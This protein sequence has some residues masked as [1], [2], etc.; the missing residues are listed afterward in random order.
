MGSFMRGY[1]LK[2]DIAKS[3]NPI[4][5]IEDLEPSGNLIELDKKIDSLSDLITDIYIHI[6]D[7]EVCDDPRFFR[8]D[9]LVA[10]GRI[11][12]I[13][14]SWA[15]KITEILNDKNN[16]PGFT[17]GDEINLYRPVTTHFDISVNKKL[18]S[19]GVLVIC[20]GT[21]F[22]MTTRVIP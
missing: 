5:N 21:L 14:F 12:I 13:D 3:K 7:K 17:V 16:V 20:N 11:S 9:L 18:I 8:K 1:M 4:E 10:R 2:V 19:S 22:L 6:L 15:I